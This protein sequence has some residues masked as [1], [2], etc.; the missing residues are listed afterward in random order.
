MRV[1]LAY[2]RARCK[3]PIAPP[4]GPCYNVIMNR[5]SSLRSVIPRVSLALLLVGILAGALAL[6]AESL[7]LDFTPGFGLVQVLGT[8]LAITLVAAAG[9]LFP[10]YRRPAGREPSLLNEIGVRLGLTGL[11]ACYVAGLADMVGVGTHRNPDFER[12]FLG[13]LQL[14]G[15]VIGLGIVATGLILYWLGCRMESREGEE[16]EE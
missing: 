8:L 10:A 14:T 15:L 11:L 12:P 4:G 16:P 1:I 2:S 3:R 13:P 6:L 7:R 5:R 9:F